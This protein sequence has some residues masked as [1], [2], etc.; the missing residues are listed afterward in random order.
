MKSELENRQVFIG[1]G[2]LGKE[3][4]DTLG[5]SGIS[6]EK[7]VYL[8]ALSEVF[9]VTFLGMCKDVY[10]D[11]L[12]WSRI[13]DV[14]P[15]LLDW[16]DSDASY[17]PFSDLPDIFLRS[18]NRQM[19]RAGLLIS[20][21]K[22]TRYLEE[23]L[24]TPE[25]VY[26]ITRSWGATGSAWVQDVAEIISD[27]LPTATVEI[28]L[29]HDLFENQPFFL[30]SQG[31]NARAISNGYWLL[32]ELENS[33]PS[34]FH[35]FQS[36]SKLLSFVLS[37]SPEQESS[38]QKSALRSTMAELTMWGFSHPQL[39]N[40]QAEFLKNRIRPFSEVIGQEDRYLLAG[41]LLVQMLDREVRISDED[42]IIRVSFCRRL[43]DQVEMFIV[44]RIHG[45][46][47][48]IV[49]GLLVGSEFLDN[50]GQRSAIEYLRGEGELLVNNG[51]GDLVASLDEALRSNRDSLRELIKH[52]VDSSHISY[53]DRTAKQAI[54]VLIDVSNRLLIED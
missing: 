43:T 7:L 5:N 15:N 11:I 33:S 31:P 34:D 38:F 46:I 35:L 29:L 39:R 22:V 26:L 25:K 48:Q 18:A 9:G 19:M 47:S 2:G 10:P 32:R 13:Q 30:Q 4:L 42:R 14:E 50:E 27:F 52:S 8:D 28:C 3:A 21:E 54:E 1:L 51:L 37:E 17:S 53:G 45:G 20:R 6:S 44:P 16:F 41:Y 23:M 40:E 12:A 24:G 36:L 49:L